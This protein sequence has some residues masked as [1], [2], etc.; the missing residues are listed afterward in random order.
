MTEKGVL[1]ASENVQG[2]SVNVLNKNTPMISGILNPIFRN[3]NSYVALIMSKVFMIIVITKLVTSSLNW[4]N[5]K[6]SN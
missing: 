6:D 2:V 1:Y 4:E 3:N 5:L